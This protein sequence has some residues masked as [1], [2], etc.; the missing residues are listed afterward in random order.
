MKRDFSVLSFLYGRSVDLCRKLFLLVCFLQQ[1]TGRTSKE[2]F[3]Q[4][5]CSLLVAPQ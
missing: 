2:H 3:F 1:G 4:H 5:F